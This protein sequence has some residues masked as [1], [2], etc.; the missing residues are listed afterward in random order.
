MSLLLLLFP[1]SLALKAFYREDA[2]FRSRLLF[3]DTNLSQEVGHGEVEWKGRAASLKKWL[4]FVK[5]LSSF[6]SLNSVMFHNGNLFF[7]YLLLG[8]LNKQKKLTGV[9]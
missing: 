2:F 6:F 1:P 9:P 4:P 5:L 7:F 8:K 3:K